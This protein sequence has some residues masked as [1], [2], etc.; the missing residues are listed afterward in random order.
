MAELLLLGRRAGDER[1]RQGGSV[2]SAGDVELLAA[3]A[4][5]RLRP[6]A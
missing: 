1:I 2:L 6:A 4:G 3:T 5:V